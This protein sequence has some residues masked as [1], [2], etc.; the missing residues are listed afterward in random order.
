MRTLFSDTTRLSLL[1]E[2]QNDAKSSGNRPPPAGSQ[3]CSCSSNPSNCSIHPNT[4]AEWAAYMRASLASLIR[5]QESAL[6]QTMSAI[7][8]R[9]PG[10]LLAK[11]DPGSCSWK[12]SQESFLTDTPPSSSPTLP[13]WG[14]TRAGGLYL[15]PTPALRTTEKGGGVWRKIP[16]PSANDWKGSSKPGQRRRQLTDPAMGVL[17]A[18]GKLNPEWDEW[19]MG[20]PIGSTELK[21]SGSGRSRSKRRSPGTRSADPET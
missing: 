14:M 9:T 20:W 17:P 12:M 21:H 6:A 2:T 5:L 8:G 18:G 10:A 15:L 1:S 4:P 13:R 7:T 16:T 11:F 19:L 3:T